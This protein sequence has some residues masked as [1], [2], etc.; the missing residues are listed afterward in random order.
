MLTYTKQGKIIFA[1]LIE[2]SLFHS[3]KVRCI[4]TYILNMALIVLT[5]N[6]ARISS[7]TT[8]GLNLSNTQYTLILKFNILEE[9]S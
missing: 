4:K 8:L 2:W 7:P 9:C 3:L 5:E 6:F 1:N